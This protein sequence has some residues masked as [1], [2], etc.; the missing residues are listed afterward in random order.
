[1]DWVSGGSPIAA[2]FQVAM[3]GR[4]AGIESIETRESETP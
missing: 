4:I 3:C 1:M 2:G